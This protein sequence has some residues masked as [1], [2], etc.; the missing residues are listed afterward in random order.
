MILIKSASALVQHLRQ[1]SATGKTIGFVPTMGALHQGHLSLLEASKKG[2]NCTVC[3]IFINPTQFNDPK[4]F[5]KYPV[6]IDKDI[7]LLEN[8]GVDILFLPLATEIYP[9]GT[10]N[11]EQYDLGV[12]ESVLEGRYRPGHFQGVCQVMNRLLDIIKPDNLYMGQ[13][14]Y[15]QC[16]VIG[17]LLKLT[18][19]AT[20]LHI[21]ETL[22]EADGLAMSSRNLR[23]NPTERKQA[24]A[25]SIILKR[26][27]Q[28]A[29]PGPLQP[30]SS[31]AEQALSEQ[32]FKVDYVAIA[33]AGTLEV[34]EEWDGQTPMVALA[35]A[36]LNEVRL[37]DNMIIPAIK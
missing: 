32:G 29:Q 21:C 4:D 12:L 16:L 11:L 13:K 19:K 14:D 37:I 31:A 23:L 24:V 1:S 26:I 35:A 6:T 17:K 9:D 15:Q 2:N 30:I 25:I 18:G 34:P 5:E 8:L 10:N 20:S 28:S 36:Y 7:E 27:C 22:R 33:D 3:S